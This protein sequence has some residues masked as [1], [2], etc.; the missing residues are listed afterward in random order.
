MTSATGTRPESGA[1]MGH[2]EGLGRPAAGELTLARVSPA[3]YTAS[4]DGVI[5]GRAN[6][7][8][9]NGAWEFYSVRVDPDFEGR[10]IASRL[11]RFALADAG[12]AGVRV[13]PTCWYVNGFLRRHAAEFAHLRHAWSADSAAAPDQ[14]SC[15]I[16]PSVVRPG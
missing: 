2:S 8:V 9:G 16:A 6:I 14:S 7:A 10:G 5:V 13:I 4:V 15:Q 11:V 1:V 12:A 3:L